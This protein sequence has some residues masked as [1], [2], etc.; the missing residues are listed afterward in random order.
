[1]VNAHGIVGGYWAVDEGVVLLGIVIAGEVSV[2]DG[3]AVVVWD[4]P[5]LKPFL[6]GFDKVDICFGQD[7]IECC[8]FFLTFSEVDS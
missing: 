1:M 5:T 7:G 2:N 6:F 4:V 3:F 8:W